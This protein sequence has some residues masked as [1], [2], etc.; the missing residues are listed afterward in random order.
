[1]ADSIILKYF[2]QLKIEGIQKI[3]AMTYEFGY[4]DD[5]LKT[6]E[7]SITSNMIGALEMTYIMNRELEN[8]QNKAKPE[9]GR[10]YSDLGSTN[11]CKIFVQIGYNLCT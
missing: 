1:M 9:L 4:E 8:L 10:Y 7:F 6:K 3:K 11:L 2:Y 5:D